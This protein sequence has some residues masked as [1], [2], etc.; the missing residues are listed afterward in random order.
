MSIK[1]RGASMQHVIQILAAILIGTAFG[2]V[3]SRRNNL[4]LVSSLIAIALGIA[5]MFTISWVPLA[6]GTVIFMIAQSMQRD[7]SPH[8][9]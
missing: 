6:A 7:K 3:L 1:T 4:L 5:T 9:G 8:E 2:A